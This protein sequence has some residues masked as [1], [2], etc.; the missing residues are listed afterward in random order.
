MK[1]NDPGLLQG[2]EFYLLG[3]LLPVLLG[4]VILRWQVEVFHQGLE[5]LQSTLWLEGN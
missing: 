5:L 4:L 1:D 2:F 3:A